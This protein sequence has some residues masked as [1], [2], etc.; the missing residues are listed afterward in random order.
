MGSGISR[1]NS[2]DVWAERWAS[3]DSLGGSGPVTPQGGS[4]ELSARGASAQERA[5]TLYRPSTSLRAESRDSRSPSKRGPERFYYDKSTYTGTWKNGGPTTTGNGLDQKTGYSD[6]SQLV[7]RGHTQ[8]DALHRRRTGSPMNSVMGSVAGSQVPSPRMMVHPADA[9][10]EVALAGLEV[11]D[12]SAGLRGARTPQ[13]GGSAASAA[14]S[15]GGSV[16]VAAA[17]GG[18]WATPVHP[19]RAWQQWVQ[20]PTWG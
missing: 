14:S 15:R 17:P 5:R 1:A 2:P 7:N 13:M 3:R 16:S 10:A 9:F 8:D 20:P 11:A 6:L 19:G 18:Q 4:V 12:A